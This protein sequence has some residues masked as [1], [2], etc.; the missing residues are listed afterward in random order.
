MAV[1]FANPKAYIAELIG[2]AI[3]VFVGCV[4]GMMGGALLTAFSVAIVFIGIIYCAEKVC[5]CHLNPLITLSMFITGKMDKEDMPWYILAQIL[6]GIIGALFALLIL[7]NEFH[8][9]AF[10]VSPSMYGR[11]YGCMDWFGAFLMEFLFATALCYIAMKATVNRKIDLKSGAI[12]AM[13]MFALIYFGCGM[14]NSIMNPAKSIGAAIATLLSSADSKFDPF[15]QLW[16]FIIAPLLGML[17]GS[18]LYLITSNSDFD[19]NEF[20]QSKKKA[21][22]VAEAAVEEEAAEETPAEEP[23]ETEEVAEEESVEEE[24]AETPVEEPAADVVIEAEPE[25]EE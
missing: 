14:N 18:F 4:A 22:P 11:D 10:F 25:K 1:N 9:S 19:L 21:K 7:S 24:P 16:L 23:A 8:T 17:L 20:I 3:L 5:D 15:L 13:A 12:I 2:T 6:G